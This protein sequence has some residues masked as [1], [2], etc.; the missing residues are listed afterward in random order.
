CSPVVA[1]VGHQASQVEDELTRQFAGAPLK[2]ALQAEQLGTGHAVLQAE[3]A[4]KGFSGSVLILAADVPLIRPDTLQKLVE[5]KKDADVSL[6]SC[7]AR[8]PKGYGRIG[9]NAR[10]EVERI[11]EE[12][13]ATPGE[14]KIDEINASI[15]LAGA[16]VL[17]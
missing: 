1:V 7:K 6:L 9:R 2:F 10:G 15:Y 14:R 11:V 5:A 12:K 4:L 17:F 8:E 3:A 13:D 16:K